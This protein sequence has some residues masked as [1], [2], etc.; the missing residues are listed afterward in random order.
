MDCHVHLKLSQVNKFEFE[1]VLK[2]YLKSMRSNINRQTAEVGSPF[3]LKAEEG[4]PVFEEGLR[5]PGEKEV[6]V[7]K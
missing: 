6:R 1:M 4:A 2:G 7:E 3:E 5:L